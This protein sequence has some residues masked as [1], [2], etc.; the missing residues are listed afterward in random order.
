MAQTVPPVHVVLIAPPG[1]HSG[2][3]SGDLVGATT[4]DAFPAPA[5]PWT[6]HIVRN[7]DVGS[8]SAINQ[9]LHLIAATRSVAVALLDDDCVLA[10]DY[11]ATMGRA[12]EHCAAVGI[13]TPW[14]VED[15]RIHTDLPP[16]FPY[17]WAWNDVGP[18]AAFR[19]EAVEEA[20]GVQMRLTG[21]DA[22][23]Q[24]CNDMMGAGWR[25][26]PFP[27]ALAS[28]SG[29]TQRARTRPTTASVLPVSG[30]TLTPREVL[31]ATPREQWDLVRRAFADP[32]YL[33]RWLAWHVR[34]ALGPRG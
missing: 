7:T 15:G 1:V 34:R 29:N 32:A 9:A 21:S 28:L 25:A 12:F 2:N 30:R 4:A 33:V 26:A 6:S 8:A 16:A 19:L 17:Q 3:L 22:V 23:W 11:V 18:C 27:A 20:G 5:S 13:V 31:F 24:L 14:H 10:P